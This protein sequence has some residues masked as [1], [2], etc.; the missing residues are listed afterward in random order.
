MTAT[1]SS[2]SA[3]W[4]VSPRSDQLVTWSWVPFAVLGA[5]VNTPQLVLVV[6]SVVLG[7]SFS[8]Q[9]LTL[10]LV[11]GDGC[12]FRSRRVVFSAAPV[13]LFVGVAV[14]RVEAFVAL[15]VLAAA[16]NAFHTVRQRYGMVRI[17]GRRVGQ[18]SPGVEQWWL[19]AGFVTAV[20]LAASTTSLEAT[21]ADGTLDLGRAGTNTQL[22]RMLGDLR[23]VARW[24]A[25]PMV[26]L[27]VALGVRWWR[28]ERN[29]PM[30]P[31]KHWYVGSTM[32]M[33]AVAPLTPLGALL[34]F[35]GSHAV[36]YYVVVVRS[37][38]SRTTTMP[39]SSLARLTMWRG[40]W[41]PVVAFALTMVALVYGA[42]LG[43]M[44]D[45]GSVV[46]FTLGAMHFLF[47]GIIWRSG[48]PAYVA[49]SFTN[50]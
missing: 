24:A 36:E 5:V 50:S 32:L 19:F 13:V 28:E 1:A 9:V 3:G 43:P 40:A 11:Y 8:H 44:R 38:R 46:A 34:G 2:Q 47:D 37:L 26:L 21:L 6:V 22:V 4:M 41:L 45:L 17:Y 31:A 49:S 10:P 35:V 39:S 48:R 42:M 7:F 30:N 29:R 27:T 33:F 16:W 20:V 18:D 15:A 14:L 23:P 12:T 25:V